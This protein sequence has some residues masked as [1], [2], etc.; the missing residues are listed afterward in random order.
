MVNDSTKFMRSG[1]MSDL[2][3]IVL[4]TFLEE[5]EHAPNK[6]LALSNKGRLIVHHIYGCYHQHNVMQRPF[7][8]PANHLCG[9]LFC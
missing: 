1:A 7:M 8:R 9:F 5:L 4:C 3:Y 6:Q 2:L